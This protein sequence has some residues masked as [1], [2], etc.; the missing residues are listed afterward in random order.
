MTVM[1]SPFR[2]I[3][4]G[5][6]DPYEPAITQ[7]PGDSRGL[8]TKS[9]V[10]WSQKRFWSYLFSIWQKIEHFE[11]WILNFE[12]LGHGLELNLVPYEA[13][14]MMRFQSSTF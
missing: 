8:M 7:R 10:T 11:F 14:G 12:I 5:L 1:E 3:M 6:Y 2:T 9:S 4:A 13:H